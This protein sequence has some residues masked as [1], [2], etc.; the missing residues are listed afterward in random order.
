[1]V[2]DL[3]DAVR[4]RVLQIVRDMKSRAFEGYFQRALSKYQDIYDMHY[5]YL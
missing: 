1:M 5:L 3:K 2:S 4:I